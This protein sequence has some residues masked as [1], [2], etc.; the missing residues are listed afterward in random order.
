MK[1]YNKTEKQLSKEI[2]KMKDSSYNETYSTY[3]E[4]EVKIQSEI[5]CSLKVNLK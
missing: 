5:Q 1:P 2:V 3:K 4:E